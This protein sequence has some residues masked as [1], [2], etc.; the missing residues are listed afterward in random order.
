MNIFYGRVAVNNL[1]ELHFRVFKGEKK[2]IGV[3]L[4]YKFKN[5]FP[6]LFKLDSNLHLS[7]LN[8]LNIQISNY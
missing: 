4:I 2:T 3:K 1:K 6:N 7:F 5:G 8:K